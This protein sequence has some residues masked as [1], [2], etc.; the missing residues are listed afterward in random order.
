MPKTVL[1]IVGHHAEEGDEPH[2][3][4]RAGAANRNGA[5]YT[6]DITGADGGRQSGAQGLELGN[7]AILGVTGD[8]F[9]FEN[10]ADGVFHPVT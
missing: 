6:D 5:C 3:E 2:P 4:H 8:V 1:G 9:I 7:G 10:C